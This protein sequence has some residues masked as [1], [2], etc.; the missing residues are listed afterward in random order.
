MPVVHRHLASQL[1][2]S[3]QR[4]PEHSRS[5]PTPDLESSDGR[6]PSLAIEVK[7]LVPAEFLAMRVRV[8]RQAKAVDYPG[9]IQGWVCSP[10]R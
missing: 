9:D 1:R 8:A 10:A 7:A 4:R 3:L 2:R 5:G 6:A